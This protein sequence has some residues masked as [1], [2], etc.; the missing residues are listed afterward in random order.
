QT[1]ATR[2]I[3]PRRLT[4]VPQEVEQEAPVLRSHGRGVEHTLAGRGGFV[5]VGFHRWV[6]LGDGGRSWRSPV[7][8]HH[9]R[10]PAITGTCSRTNRRGRG[11]W[12]A[13]S[14]W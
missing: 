9:P 3:R 11:S 10:G 4:L 6:R 2:E 14:G 8:D 12:S 5:G 7:G 1:R 13:S